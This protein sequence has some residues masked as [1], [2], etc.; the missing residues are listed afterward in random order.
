MT[1]TAQQMANLKD[2]LIAS[3]DNHGYDVRSIVGR[4]AHEIAR[5]PAQP[6]GLRQ[7]MSRLVIAS[8]KMGWGQEHDGRL[9]NARAENEEAIRLMQ[10][11]A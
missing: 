6:D 9:R 4:V 2:A 11:V 10:P 1:M 8:S 3:Y 7:I 5:D